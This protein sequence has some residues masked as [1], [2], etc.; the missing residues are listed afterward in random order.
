M[1]ESIGKER[2]IDKEEW[3]RNRRMR[4]LLPEMHKRYETIKVLLE[5]AASGQDAPEHFLWLAQ[6]DLQAVL[7]VM[8]SEGQAIGEIDFD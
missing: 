7:D 6:A 4:D 8:L 5:Q 2:W 1:S 3:L